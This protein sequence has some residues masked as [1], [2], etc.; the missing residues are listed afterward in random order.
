MAAKRKEDTGLVKYAPHLGRHV[1]DHV[2]PVFGTRIIVLF[3]TIDRV[4][5]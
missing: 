3:L 1:V 2:V 4:N 5:T